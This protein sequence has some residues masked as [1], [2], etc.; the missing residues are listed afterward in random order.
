MRDHMF[1]VHPAPP[2]PG[3]IKKANKLYEQI[4]KI[5]NEE[6]QYLNPDIWQELPF[7]FIGEIPRERFHVVGR[8]FSYMGRKKFSELHQAFGDL[9]MNGF[10]KLLLFGTM[11]FGK[12]HIVAALVCFLL[13]QGKRVVFLP[14]CKAMLEDPV[15]YLQAALL[16]A[17]HGDA[18]AQ[19]RVTCA[20]SAD[21]L[22]QFC[23]SHG[24]DLLFIVDQ[25]N[26]FDADQLDSATA[27]L[28]KSVAQDLVIKSSIRSVILKT[29]SANNATS[30]ED[31]TKQ[32]H[33]KKL[34]WFGGLSPVAVAFC[35]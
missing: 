32:T 24:E 3:E 10:R 31:H 15:E 25:F 2:F 6:N 21:E 1:H 33:N 19:H 9:S 27:T 14:D 13:R 26:A 23:K 18:E 22:T 4:T 34:K 17:M 12:S 30:R 7:P 11:G 8:T 28:K 20:R 29:A 5:S 35:C 16:L